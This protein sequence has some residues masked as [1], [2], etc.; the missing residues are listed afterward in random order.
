M[1]TATVE[2][3]VVLQQVIQIPEWIVDLGSFR[4]WAR[5]DKYPE[6]ARISYLNGGVWID[7]VKEQVFSHNQV[8]NEFTFVLTGLSKTE[9]L[10]RF[11]PDGVLLS[12]V[13]AD[14]S[15]GPD[16]TFV[17]T[18]SFRS[19]RVRLVKGVGSGYVEL[20]GAPDMVLEVVSQSSVGKDLVI[21]KGLYGRA[22]IK[23]YWL[24]DAR[25]EE[26]T[27]DIMR[28]D[29]EGYAPVRKQ[30]GWQKSG[31]FGK[32]FK[33]TVGKDELGYPEYTLHVR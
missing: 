7:V 20:E 31:T 30:A 26:I 18:K 14:L 8:K 32:S 23:E 25:R 15:S 28:L 24:V 3:P 21:L 10:G 11:F 33:F 2:K 9:R 17:S 16:G 19:Q 1:S 22:G 4:R 5:S 6:K 27:F 29:S 12:N 13:D